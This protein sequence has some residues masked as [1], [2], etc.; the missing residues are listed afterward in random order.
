MQ[1]TE[2]WWRRL[3]GLS[4]GKQHKWFSLENK[5]K[6]ILDLIWGFYW[7]LPNE[8]PLGFSGQYILCNITV[9]FLSILSFILIIFNRNKTGNYNRRW[10]LGA[11]LRAH[12][13]TLLERHF[14][15]Y[16]AWTGKMIFPHQ[17]VSLHKSMRFNR[18]QWGV[19]AHLN[20]STTRAVPHI[21]IGVCFLASTLMKSFPP[22]FSVH[23]F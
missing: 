10:V 19:K 22:T 17:P 18:C 11:S 8:T 21:S 6:P 5:K 16:C 14:A 7:F 4:N 15:S 13:D 3:W 2:V 20:R 1:R 12:S 9:P 23:A